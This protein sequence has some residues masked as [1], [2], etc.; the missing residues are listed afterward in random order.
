[1]PTMDSTPLS[2]FPI[3]D[4]AFQFARTTGGPGNLSQPLQY[5][6]WTERNI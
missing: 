5:I 3:M 2:L 6:T 1:M 4:Y